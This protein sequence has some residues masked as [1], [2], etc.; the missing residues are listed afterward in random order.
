MSAEL[1][2]SI[3]A[4]SSVVVARR[5]INGT[6]QRR[7]EVTCD[8]GTRTTFVLFAL[9]EECSR[10][11][12]QPDEYVR[13]EDASCLVERSDKPFSVECSASSGRPE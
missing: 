11:I 8:D 5:Q 3:H 2:M 12:E 6:W 9:N 7:I 4:V 10:L 1:Q 13:V